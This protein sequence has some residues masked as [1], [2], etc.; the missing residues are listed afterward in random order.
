MNGVL[1]RLGDLSVD[2][3]MREYWQKKPV[4]IR[5]LFGDW[6]SPVSPEDLMTLATREDAD[7]RLILTGSD[8]VELYHGPFE[9]GEL[10]DLPAT[11]W[12]VLV[13]EVDRLLPAVADLLGKFRFLPNWRL[14][15]VMISYAAPGGGVGAHTDQYD[16]FLVQGSGRRR[17]EIETRP[18]S[19]P[20]WRDDTEV[21]MLAQF[22]PDAVWVLEP[23]DVLYLPP[24]IPHNGVA[25]EA[26]LT[27]SVGCRAPGTGELL[28][29]VLGYA[30]EDWADED[31]YSDPD[32][33]ATIDPGLFA[34]EARAVLRDRIRRAV[35]DDQLLDRWLG[36]YVTEP[37]RGHSGTPPRRWVSLNGL[38]RRLEA[39]AS[40]RPAVVS[41]TA[42]TE[43]ADGS[44]TLFVSGQ[45]YPMPSG[46]GWAARLLTGARPL[47][48][49]C[50]EPILAETQLTELLVTLVNAGAMVLRE[51]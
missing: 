33:S 20:V 1:D 24:M 9:D 18:R 3:F 13:Q 17:W 27:I 25:L 11:E 6:V 48:A 47:D 42:Y 46:S 30:A 41:Q 40:L 50:L 8:P 32:A 45:A 36:R 22:E 2:R 39:G 29:G 7:S 15:D 19:N 14:D 51:R 38:K 35:S 34:P 43:Q 23:G 12:T 31:R 10:K 44:V 28:A 16:V 26:C 37:A 5:N 49:A 21:A 4:L